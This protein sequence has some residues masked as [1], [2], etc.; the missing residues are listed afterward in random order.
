LR[1]ALVRTISFLSYVILAKA[2]IQSRCRGD[3]FEALRVWIPAF[4]GMTS[5]DKAE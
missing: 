3:S 4:A 5:G 2:G 1:E